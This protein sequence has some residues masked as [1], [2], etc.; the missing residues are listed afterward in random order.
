MKLE[1]AYQVIIGLLVF[2]LE[3]KWW[4]YHLPL[5]RLKIL[6]ANCMYSVDCCKTICSSYPKQVSGFRNSEWNISR[7]LQSF[8]LI[9]VEHN[10]CV[11][12][13]FLEEE[14]CEKYKLS[15]SSMNSGTNMKSSY[16]Y[17]SW[18][19]THIEVKQSV[20]CLS[21]RQVN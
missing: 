9:F 15:S 11:L 14:C 1:I 5:R 19:K 17:C 8:A 7:D 16:D 6:P 20:T 21:V 13:D 3:Q 10:Q 2:L 12:S 18:R 4:N